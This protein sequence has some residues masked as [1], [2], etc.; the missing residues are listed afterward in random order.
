VVSQQDRE[1]LILGKNPLWHW[2][3]R[4]ALE[5]MDFG[6]TFSAGVV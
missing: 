6:S 3:Q 2:L 5:S 4:P 1:S